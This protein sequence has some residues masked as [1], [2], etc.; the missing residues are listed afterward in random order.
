MAQPIDLSQIQQQQ[1]QQPQIP[2]GVFESSQVQV[3]AIN[4]PGG[5]G[6]VGIFV[7][8]SRG[9]FCFGAPA[10]EAIDLGKQITAQG[11][12]AMTGLQI[13]GNPVGPEDEE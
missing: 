8:T 5:S 13:V 12:A 6:W 1:V 7:V 3:Q 10:R 2:T 11:R 9:L 4:V